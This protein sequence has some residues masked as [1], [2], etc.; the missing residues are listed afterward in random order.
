MANIF[1]LSSA[2]P[3]HSPSISLHRHYI[4]GLCPRPPFSS[5]ESLRSLFSSQQTPLFP[6]PTTSPPYLCTSSVSECK[7]THS[8]ARYNPSFRPGT[9]CADYVLFLD[10]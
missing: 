7:P 6:H 10:C 8:P 4:L 3:L 9:D 2:L 1:L 5:Y